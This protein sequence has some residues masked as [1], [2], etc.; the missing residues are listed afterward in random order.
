MN[1]DE[2]EVADKVKK[3]KKAFLKGLKPKPILKGS[4]WADRYRMIAVG[5]SPEPGKW[6]TARVPYQKEI[7]DTVTKK[8]VT[9]VVI[10]AASQIGKSE[11]LMNLL[12]YYI[13][14]EP[15]TILLI[16]PTQDNAKA[17]VKERINPTIN[18]S[19][20]LKELIVDEDKSI[21][22]TSGNTLKEKMFPGG[23]LA[24]IGARS[25]NDLAS[26]PIRVVLAD[27]ID[28]YEA[29]KEGDPLKLAEQRT[30]N[31]Y[32]HKI[33]TVSTPT[34]KDKGNSI[35]TIYKL[36]QDTDQRKYFIPC[37]ICS[38][39]SVW[40]W[41]MV[42]WEKD[43]QN[44]V[45]DDTVRLECPY[46]NG[47]IRGSGKPNP[48]L[49]EKGIW[50][51]TNPQNKDKIGFHIT[52]L[53]SPWVE[54]RKLVKEFVAAARSKSRDGLQEFFNLKMGEPYD[55]Y[56]TESLLWQKLKRRAENYT[57]KEIP[58]EIIFLTAGI[59]VQ[60]D[61]VECSIYGW[62][63]NYEGWL[64]QHLIFYGDPL[65]D[66]VWN[67]LDTVLINKS[68]Q[69]KN[70]ETRT[71]LFSFVDS[72]D[73]TTTEAVYRYTTPRAAHFIFSIK[74]SSV[75]GDL[76]VNKPKKVNDKK[77][78]LFSLNVF[79]AK[80]LI[81]NMLANNEVGAN[82]LHFPKN[83]PNVND[84]FYEQLTSEVLLKIKN[85]QTNVETEKWK[86]IRER[87]ESLDCLV[88]AYCAMRY[89]LKRTSM[90]NIKKQVL[91]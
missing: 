30:T 52:S 42:K 57:D 20:A 2:L 69:T 78:I 17:F 91:R 50:R 84:E 31:F 44:N 87:N 74:G 15:S 19:P 22:K 35:P 88:Y 32:N 38:K 73:G 59:D 29:T 36:F 64:I 71:L 72:G 14:Q 41:S 58:D 33:V 34:V 13:A 28:R 43:E 27:E 90:D 67:D 11:I 5:T 9:H 79:S 37:P 70:K 83:A 80:I 6:S 76:L 48:H 66:K 55:R 47:K 18:A 75:N 51:A 24:V 4:E 54:L 62:G 60:R 46:C 61:R 68:W 49:L 21:N 39:E 89:L 82:Y 26:K 86:K 40:N 77:T 7:L 53:C 25:P 1:K 63:E 8:T 65:Q 45:I 85:K 56:S 23:F 16:Q 3:L 81:N 10:M 12:G